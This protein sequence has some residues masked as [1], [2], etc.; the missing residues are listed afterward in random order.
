M[1]STNGA[2]YPNSLDRIGDGDVRYASLESVN[3]SL[4]SDWRGVMVDNARLKDEV[5][6]WRTWERARRDSRPAS[7]LAT[8]PTYHGPALDP[9]YPSPMAPPLF[10]SAF[11]S[12]MYP[13]W[14]SPPPP[15]RGH[16]NTKRYCY[17]PSPC[18]HLPPVATRI[19]S[20][21]HLRTPPFPARPKIPPSS[22]PIERTDQEESQRSRS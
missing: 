2:L 12:S 19:P 15:G 20:A 3:C 5:K 4:K 10:T 22:S 17:P 1:L 6:R 18:Q 8:I 11:Y 16:T 7:V 13:P 9:S 14:H 21:G